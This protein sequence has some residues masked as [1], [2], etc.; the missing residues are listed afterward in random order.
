MEQGNN[1]LIKTLITLA[2]TL[3]VLVVLFL[4]WKKVFA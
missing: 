3:V 4:I 2:A 1:P